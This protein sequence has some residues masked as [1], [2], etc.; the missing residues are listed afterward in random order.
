MESATNS[1]SDLEI[2]ISFNRTITALQQMLVTMDN[3]RSHPIE[4]LLQQMLVKI[5]NYL[6]PPIELL[7]QQMLVK[8][9]NYLSPPIELLLQQMLVMIVRDISLIVLSP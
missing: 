6:S 4:L 8:I 3:Y 5:D 7:L 1:G 2:S 9:D